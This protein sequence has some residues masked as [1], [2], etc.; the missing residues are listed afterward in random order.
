MTV[1]DPIARFQEALT[2]AHAQC[3][4]DPT[5]MSLATA[6]PTGA[7][8]VRIVLLKGVDARGFSFYTNRGSRKGEE[9]ERNPR[10]ALC[11]YWPEL[12]EQ[13]RIEGRVEHLPNPESDAYFASRPR[14]SQLGAWASRQSRPLSSRQVLM[15]RFEQ[16][17]AEHADHPVPRPGWW[18]GY[19]V[20]PH[21]I[22]FWKHGSHRLHERT[23]YQREGEGPEWT[24]ELL[25]P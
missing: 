22:E 3:A 25:N 20:I 8:S 16:L 1:H 17:T 2:R 6:D 13:V 5:A 15:E 10:A 9:L 19:L 11:V 4:H 24:A 21:S 7:P 14:E 23:L 12:G 18:G